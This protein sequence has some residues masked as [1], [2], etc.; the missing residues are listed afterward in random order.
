MKVL[1]IL[2]L[3]YEEQL[4]WFLDKLAHIHGC[5][6]DLL[7]TGPSFSETSVSAIRAFKPD[8]RFLACENVGYDV[9]PFLRAFQEISPD[10]YDWVLKLHTKGNT[11]S[12]KIRINGTHLTGFM[13]RDIL[14]DAL[15]ADDVRWGEVLNACS[16]L[17]CG[18]VCSRKL[19]AQLGFK[20]DHSL[21]D[22]E[23]TRIGL[24]TDERRFCIGT[25]FMLRCSLLKVLPLQSFRAEDFPRESASNSG[26]TLAHTYERVLSLLA[27]AQGYE[28]VTT[29]SDAAFERKQRFRH[30]TKPVLDFLF[31]IDRKG[32]EGR[33]YLT[34]LGIQ[35]PLSK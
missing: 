33:K 6:W 28:V 21:L 5:D 35:I 31:S 17:E 8:A 32:E 18:M 23:L 13:W 12:H 16:R 14:V 4:G 15:L 2:H 11:G 7:L 24:R 3:Y 26:G 29:G 10:D 34:I 30:I 19:Y 27:P 25:M 1:V 22:D 20:E 9:W